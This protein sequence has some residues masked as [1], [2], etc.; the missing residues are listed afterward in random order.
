M[1]AEFGRRQARDP[2]SDDAVLLVP[3]GFE[4]LSETLASRG[5]VGFACAEIG[6]RYGI[7][8]TSLIEALEGLA[9]TYRRVNGDEPSFAAV[10]ALTVSWSDA[11]LQY[12]HALTCEDPLTGLASL[13]HL[14]LRL[15]EIYRAENAWGRTAGTTHALVVV[16]QVD[17]TD[18]H[19]SAPTRLERAI[20][21]TDTAE[22]L[23]LVYSAGETIGKASS[24]RAVAIVAK[25][26]R[27]GDSIAVLQGLLTDWHRDRGRPFPRVWIE[28]LPSSEGAAGRLLDELAR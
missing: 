13:T 10:R 8:G 22:C 6:R 26:E 21:L 14:R 23:R 12:L 2:T 7:D 27:L 9:E 20:R 17:Q 4:A 1:F 5:D 18:T 28:G 11:A 24:R 16:E 25:N 3:E 15:A 19:D